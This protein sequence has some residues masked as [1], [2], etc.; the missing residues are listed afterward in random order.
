MKLSIGSAVWTRN[1]L[2]ASGL[3]PS[4]PL[5]VVSETEFS[6]SFGNLRF[7]RNHAGAV[8][9]LILQGWRAILKLSESPN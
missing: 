3:G 8:T 7:V 4:A 1:R 6:A 5:T 9:H 2:L